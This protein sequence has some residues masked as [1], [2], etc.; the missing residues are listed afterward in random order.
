MLS[1]LEK[2]ITE[3]L[4]KFCNNILFF[5]SN[6]NKSLVVSIFHYVIFILGFI[7]FS[8][9]SN[10]GDYFRVIFFVFILFSAISYFTINRCI[11]TSIELNLSKEKNLIQKT[12]DKYFGEETEGNITSKIILT[13]G[14]IITGLVLLKDYE[15]LHIKYTYQK[16]AH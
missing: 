16:G 2:T 3:Y 4:T 7:Y 14:S 8:F 13:I 5:L 9:Y 11:L 1:D 12:I 10:P 6:N 15:Y